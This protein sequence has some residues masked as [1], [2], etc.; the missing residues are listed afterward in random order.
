ME[1]YIGLLKRAR[2]QLRSRPDSL[3]I[4]DLVICPK[5][6]VFS[7]LD[8]IPITDEELYDY[9]SGQ[10]SHD[11]IERLFMMYPDRFRVEREVEYGNVRGKI[12]IMTNHSIT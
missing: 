5:K 11:V 1:D 12:D 3:A 7:T 9:V 4:K 2:Q 10:A 8:P 6:K